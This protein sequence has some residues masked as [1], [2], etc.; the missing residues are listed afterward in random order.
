MSTHL[1]HQAVQV[2]PA[3]WHKRRIAPHGPHQVTNKHTQPSTS[4]SHWQL[5]RHNPKLSNANHRA[6]GRRIVISRP[7]PAV[8][9]SSTPTAEVYAVTRACAPYSFDA[10][11][12]ALAFERGGIIQIVDR[13]MGREGGSGV[14][15]QGIPRSTMSCA[16][17]RLLPHTLN[18]TV[19]VVFGDIF[20]NSPQQGRQP[21]R[22]RKPQCSCKAANIDRW[23]AMLRILDPGKDHTDKTIRTTKNY[24]IPL[25]HDA[26]P[27]VVKRA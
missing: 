11:P 2:A 16:Y 18:G 27:Q 5:Q 6:Y 13:W 14:V 10:E 12:G 7:T 19:L 4:R 23:L 24:I 25:M 15:I 9:Q 1:R 3:H 26:L 21:K 22:S 17:V 20:R 8:P